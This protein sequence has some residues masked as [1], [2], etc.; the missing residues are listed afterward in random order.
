[1]DFGSVV[2][3][4]WSMIS[5]LFVWIWGALN[6]AFSIPIF[7]FFLQIAFYALIGWIGYKLYVRLPQRVKRVTRERI[8]PFASMLS[9]PVRWLLVR[10][11]ADPEWLRRPGD[12]GPQ[13]VEREIE[14][15]VYVRRSFRSWLWSAV[16]WSLF[17]AGTLLIIQNWTKVYEF[18]RAMVPN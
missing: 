4:V 10:W 15:E 7:G 1:M 18:V 12:S 11:L 5:A 13:I 9:R 17:G 16:R 3:F 6:F 14:V 8:G 2:V